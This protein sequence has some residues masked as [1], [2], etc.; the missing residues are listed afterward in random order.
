M[1]EPCRPDDHDDVRDLFGKD[2]PRRLAAEQ[3]DQFV[4]NY[5]DDLFGRL[6]LLPNLLPFGLF[7]DQR[8]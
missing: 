7:L 2:Q 1:P 5:L 4:V 3:V 6:E 8:R